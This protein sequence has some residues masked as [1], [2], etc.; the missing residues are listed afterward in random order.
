MH[1]RYQSKIALCL[2][3]INTNLFIF[4]KSKKQRSHPLPHPLEHPQKHR[5]KHTLHSLTP[6]SSLVILRNKQV[7]NDKDIFFSFFI[8]IVYLI[9]VGVPSKL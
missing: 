2:R 4:V 7:V 5:T 6:P 3:G 9:G 1:P 8:N